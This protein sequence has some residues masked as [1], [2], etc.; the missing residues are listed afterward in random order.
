[1]KLY[2]IIMLFIGIFFAPAGCDFFEEND[3]STS[4]EIITL[5]SENKIHE[6]RIAPYSP[7]VSHTSK[8]IHL[9][10]PYMTDITSLQPVITISDRATIEPES[11]S[12]QNFTGPVCYT[13]TA[14]NG[15]K[16]IYTVYI[17]TS[18]EHIPISTISGPYT[19]EVWKEDTTWYG[20]TIV[21][22]GSMSSDPDI[23]SG[24]SIV[25]YEWALYLDGTIVDFPGTDYDPK[26]S[27][28]C[29][30]LYSL[31]NSAGALFDDLVINEPAN[32]YPTVG[33]QLIV[34]D[35]SGYTSRNT[36][37][38]KLLNSKF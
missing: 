17:S 11:A 32:P 16:A 1:M 2:L 14:E 20:N 5:S 23:P 22:D 36:T 34:T 15:D 6:F 29:S 28:T 7:Y 30:T 9:S 13:V 8:S 19:M 10:L 37:F 21:L 25:R 4:K 26:P 33:V 27:L 31:I 35:E 3:S 12:I 24:D 18:N 38:I